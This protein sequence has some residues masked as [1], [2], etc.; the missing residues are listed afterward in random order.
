MT[1]KVIPITRPMSDPDEARF[2]SLGVHFCQAILDNLEQRFPGTK[3]L[4]PASCFFIRGNAL[5]QLC[6]KFYLSAT[7]TAD[8]L[9]EFAQ[10]K[11]GKKRVR[12][13]LMSSVYP[14]STRF[15]QMNL[16]HTDTRNRLTV[17]TVG[18]A[19]MLSINGP[20]LEHWGPRKYVIS[21]LITGRQGALY[22]PIGLP[23]SSD[24]W[25]CLQTA[26]QLVYHLIV[27]CIGWMCRLIDI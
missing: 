22:K 8:F 19:L 5:V 6:K 10:Y 14:I 12:I 23:K 9:F 20:P 21:W 15:S 26:Y 24:N 11:K 27:C 25:Q 7:E 3:V 17:Q 4:D 2:K 13:C 18:N 16:Q 1:Y